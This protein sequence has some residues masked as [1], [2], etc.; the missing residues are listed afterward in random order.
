MLQLLDSLADSI[1]S[2]RGG[3][4]RG[5]RSMST[6][7]NNLQDRVLRDRLGEAALF[8]GCY[9][10]MRLLVSAT[11][12]HGIA[13]ILVTVIVAVA[14]AEFLKRLLPTRPDG[15]KLPR[16]FSIA[17]LIAAV[18]AVVLPVVL[19]DTQTSNP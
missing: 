12:L 6:G 5:G 2:L 15:R 13:R 17:L 3:D 14:L 8:V 18:I 10:G 19:M 1:A 4:V 11:P 16:P 7:S 9:S